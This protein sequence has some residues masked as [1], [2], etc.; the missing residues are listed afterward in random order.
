M[1]TFEF[2]GGLGDIFIDCYLHDHYVRLD[3]LKSGEKATVVFRSE[4]PFAKELASV[5]PKA[6]Q[7]QIVTLNPWLPLTKQYQVV[8]RGGRAEARVIFHPT[9][10]DLEAL[11]TLPK[12]FMVFGLST[13]QTSG[14]KNIPSKWADELA[15]HASI[16][17]YAPVVIGRTYLHPMDGNRTETKVSGDVIDLTDKLSVHGL[18]RLVEMSSGCVVAYSSVMLLS[19]LLRKPTFTLYPDWASPEWDEK[20]YSTFGQSYPESRQHPFSM[21][22]KDFFDGFLSEVVKRV[23]ST[24]PMV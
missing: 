24:P 22:S 15:R 21:Y 17:G 10:R 3:A 7:F 18:H 14:R 13:G 23:D 9:P 19:W 8:P 11:S 5:H 6:S 2:S 4:N 20:R 1:T 12:K 16:S